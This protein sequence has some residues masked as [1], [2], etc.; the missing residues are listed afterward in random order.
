MTAAGID[1]ANVKPTLRPRYTLA[2]VKTS[3]IAA[4]SS[5]PRKVSSTRARTS[6]ELARSAGAGNPVEVVAND[7]GFG[8]LCGIVAPGVAGLGGGVIW[9]SGDG[10]LSG[11]PVGGGEVV[12]PAATMCGVTMM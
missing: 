11:R 3:V 9:G 7:Y 1:D 10:R 6:A 5:R 4:P 12:P 2:A 8:R